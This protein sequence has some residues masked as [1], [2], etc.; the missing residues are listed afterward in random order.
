MLDV[1]LAKLR[2]GHEGVFA[3]IKESHDRIKGVLLRGKSVYT[4]C[5]GQNDLNSL[6]MCP[7]MRV[8][9]TYPAPSRTVLVKEDENEGGPEAAEHGE[10][11]DNQ[12][13]HHRR[14]D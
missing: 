7:R 8:T 6:A 9:R 14:W 12:T 3:V 4:N 10:E 5:E 11:T 2:E 13:H 1:W